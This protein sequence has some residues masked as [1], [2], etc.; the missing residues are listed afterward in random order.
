MVAFQERH[1]KADDLTEARQTI[2]DLSLN[3][4]PAVISDV[5][6]SNEKGT[7]EITSGQATSVDRGLTPEIG[8][9][10]GQANAISWVSGPAVRFCAGHPIKNSQCEIPDIH[11]T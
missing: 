7:G 5:L 3:A 1:P 6:G 10:N 4:N 9:S 8:H 11:A 2:G